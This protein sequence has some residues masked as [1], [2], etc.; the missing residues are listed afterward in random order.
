[1]NK[2]LKKRLESLAYKTSIPFCY[3]CYIDAPKGRCKKCY[4]DDLMRHLPGV[5]VEY[6]LEWVIE[7]II[8]ENLSPINTEEIFEQSIDDCYGDTVQVGWLSLNPALVIKDQDPISWD[9]AK[10]E[11]FDNLCGDGEILEFSGSYYWADEVEALL[12]ESEAS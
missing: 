9:M 10:S 11:Y 5:G 12:V 3:H 1:M 4:S 6:G 8:N 7:S 2:E